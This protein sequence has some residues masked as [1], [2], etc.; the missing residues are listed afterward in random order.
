MK[1][2]HCNTPNA[3]V[4]FNSVE[5]KNSRCKHFEPTEEIICPCCGISGHTPTYTQG[6]DL[7]NFKDKT[8]NVNFPIEGL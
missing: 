7:S 8:G 1:C 5:C 3:Y 6:I 2:P 4:G